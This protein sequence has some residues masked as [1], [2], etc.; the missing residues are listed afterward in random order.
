MSDNES[1]SSIGDL[2]LDFQDDS[3]D[4]DGYRDRPYRNEEAIVFV[5]VDEKFE[6]MN[7]VPSSTVPNDNRVHF[8]INMQPKVSIINEQYSN[9]N[10]NENKEHKQ[11]ANDDYIYTDVYNQSGQVALDDYDDDYEDDFST[12][13]SFDDSYYSDDDENYAD[14]DH[15][16]VDFNSSTTHILQNSLHSNQPPHVQPHLLRKHMSLKDIYKYKVS[17]FVPIEFDICLLVGSPLTI[18]TERNR[19]KIPFK[20]PRMSKKPPLIASFSNVQT[21]SKQTNM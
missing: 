15:K 12:D 17:K 2:D 4:E 14:T 9:D 19:N 13:E 5:T 18:K 21:H 7:N 8:E 16:I 20:S 1:H 10:D 3:D 11:N 6:V